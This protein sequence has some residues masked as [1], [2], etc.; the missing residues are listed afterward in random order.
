MLVQC[1][2]GS[3]CRVCNETCE[4]YCKYSCDIDNGGCDEDSQ[5]VEVDVPTCRSGQCCSPVNVMC[6]STLIKIGYL[7]VSMHYFNNSG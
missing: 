6:R 5:C 2:F 4:T 3:R 7:C 1:P